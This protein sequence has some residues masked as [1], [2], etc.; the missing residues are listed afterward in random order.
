MFLHMALY[1]FKFCM[2][3]T[4]SERLLTMR[5][6][7]LTRALL[8]VYETI[9]LFV[10]VWKYMHVSV[11][12]LVCSSSILLFSATKYACVLLRICVGAYI[13]IRVDI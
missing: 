11:R 7:M 3:I 6:R 10:R 2:P 13:R 1:V 8:C 5:A 4:D 12:G 9:Y